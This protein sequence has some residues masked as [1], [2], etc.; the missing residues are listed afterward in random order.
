MGVARGGAVVHTREMTP[1]RDPNTT[2]NADRGRKMATYT[3]SDEARDAIE[4]LAKASGKNRSQTVEDA[5]ILMLRLCE[6][7]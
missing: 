5:V 6:P 1:R 4:E 7:R 3:L 2:T